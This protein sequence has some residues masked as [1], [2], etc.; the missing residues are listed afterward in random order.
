MVEK[1]EK[2]VQDL[3]GQPQPA[4]KDTVE[5]TASP[6]ATSGDPNTGSNRNTEKKKPT[7]T[8]G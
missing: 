2:I 7:P 1:N 8:A 5:R 3:R 4:D 6:K